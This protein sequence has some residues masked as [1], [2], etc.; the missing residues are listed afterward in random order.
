[1][2]ALKQVV[3]VAALLLRRNGETGLPPRRRESCAR[4]PG[5]NPIASRETH[6]DLVA[7]NAL[8]LNGSP[9]TWVG[10]S[11]PP[12]CASPHSEELGGGQVTL[13]RSA[14]CEIHFRRGRSRDVP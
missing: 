9:P 1:M 2:S 13:R 8:T 6:P 4:Q 3:A 12:H 10:G 7:G 14:E 11:S 5:R